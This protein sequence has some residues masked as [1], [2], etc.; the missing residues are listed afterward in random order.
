[1]DSVMLEQ[2]GVAQQFISRLLAERKALDA[3]Y[4]FLELY[5]DAA[6]GIVTLQQ[7]MATL[8]NEV[9]QYA[10]LTVKKQNEYSEMCAGY[11][12]ALKEQ[13]A[14]NEGKLSELAQKIQVS[15]AMYQSNLEKYQREVDGVVSARESKVLMLDEAIKEKEAQLTTIENKYAMLKKTLSDTFD[16]LTV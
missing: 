12:A 8:Q 16:T 15:Q 3:A 5:K 11:D 2:V 14:V 9:E 10:I 7:E 4:T 1:M 13:L 6:V